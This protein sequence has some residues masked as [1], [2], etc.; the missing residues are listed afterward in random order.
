MQD[1]DLEIG[2]HLKEC[3]CM[4]SLIEDVVNT[5]NLTK[6]KPTS[7]ALSPSDGSNYWLIA[8]IISYY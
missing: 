8:V 5:C 7:V 6:E 4:I 3:K 2:E 1:K